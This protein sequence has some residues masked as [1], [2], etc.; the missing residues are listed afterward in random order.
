MPRE[1]LMSLS[2]GVLTT[3]LDFFNLPSSPLRIFPFAPA[4][5]ER[6]RGAQRK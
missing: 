6:K 2:R 4:L 5:G 3:D 1:E